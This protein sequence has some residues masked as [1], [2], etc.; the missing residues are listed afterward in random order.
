[1]NLNRKVIEVIGTE[2]KTQKIDLHIWDTAGQEKFLSL[3]KSKKK[4]TLLKPSRFF[5]ES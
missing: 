5:Q 2:G 4:A 1:M 3:T